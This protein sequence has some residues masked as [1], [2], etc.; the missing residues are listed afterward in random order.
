MKYPLFLCGFMASGKSSFGMK[1]A[2][3]LGLDFIETDVLIEQKE[4][5]SIEK[6]F[7]ESGEPYFRELER[8]V[9]HQ[10]DYSKDQVI[11]LGGGTICNDEDLAFIQSKGTIFYLRLD[12]SI[13]IGRLRE[14]REKR[15][16]TKGL[17][18]QAITELVME[19]LKLREPYYLK[20]HHVVDIQNIKSL[21]FIK[22]YS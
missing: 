7:E 2:R 18:D 1:L 12:P 5:R 21:D 14:N 16:L 6:I 3:H 9:L 22:H 10:I 15:P 13:L 4:G 19:R 20:A 11:A 8:K 17:S